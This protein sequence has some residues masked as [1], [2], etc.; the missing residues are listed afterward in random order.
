M[1]MK[2]WAER[3]IK[4]ACARE[5]VDD[6]DYIPG[7]F[8]YGVACYESALKAFKSLIEDEH[9]GFSIGLTK[10]ILNRLI[11]GKPLTP[12]EDTDDIWEF[13]FERDD[14]K[15]YQCLRMSSLFKR[16]Y[17]DG[18]I[19][20]RDSHR[21]VGVSVDDGNRLYFYNGFLT[22]LVHE[23]FPIT[24]PYMPTEES[25]K[26][27][28]NDFVYDPINGDFDTFCIRRI[29]TPDRNG[30]TINRYFKDDKSENGFV[31]ISKYEYE[32]RYNVFI[33][34]IDKEV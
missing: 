14:F 22:R 13:S 3:E 34:R 33:N 19:E 6:P 17:K 15:D 20:Y 4:I 29:V 11:D 12:I 2:E 5:V 9:S 26:V 23:M 28:R 24:M 8:N 21:A 30:I 16:V 25:Y 10:H 1:N 32:E 27:Y 31:E 18:R 7:D